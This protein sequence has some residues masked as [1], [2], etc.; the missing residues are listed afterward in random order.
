MLALGGGAT[1]LHR[2]AEHPSPAKGEARIGGKS[3]ILLQS[4]G[5]CLSLSP[6]RLRGENAASTSGCVCVACVMFLLF[7]TPSRVNGT[8]L[9]HFGLSSRASL[10][11]CDLLDGP[12]GAN[13]DIY[14]QR[15]GGSCCFYQAAPL[16]WAGMSRF[17]L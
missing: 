17:D 8:F 5:L 14:N 3:R 6:I 16:R 2:E 12:F 4:C 9:P 15:K 13:A 1:L 10:F 11:N 7:C